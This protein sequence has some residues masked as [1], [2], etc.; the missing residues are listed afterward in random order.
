MKQLKIMFGALPGSLRFLTWQEDAPITL[1]LAY[2]SFVPAY[3]GSDWQLCAYC[4]DPLAIQT[5]ITFSSISKG[6]GFLEGY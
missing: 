1:A 2:V 3:I 4:R 6:V 5:R